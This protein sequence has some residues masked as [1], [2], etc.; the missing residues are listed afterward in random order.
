MIFIFFYGRKEQFYISHL[1]PYDSMSPATMIKKK[2]KNEQW[3]ANWLDVA[4]QQKKMMP[5]L[6]GRVGRG[7]GCGAPP[8]QLRYQYLAADKVVCG[9]RVFISLIIS[10]ILVMSIHFVDCL[11]WIV[12]FWA[13]VFF[14][15]LFLLIQLFWAQLFAFA[16]PMFVNYLLLFCYLLTM[17]SADTFSQFKT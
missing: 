12:L 5:S 15:R 1:L 13:Y 4:A 8:K 11:I 10:W 9:I 14:M 16:N 6:V 7:G 17:F 3:I 2:K